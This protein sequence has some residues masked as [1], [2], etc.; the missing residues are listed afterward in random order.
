MSTLEACARAL[1]I[2]DSGEEAAA[3]AAHMEVAGS[4]SLPRLSTHVHP[5]FEPLS[6]MVGALPLFNPSPSIQTTSNPLSPL[7]EHHSLTLTL[8]LR[9]RSILPYPVLHKTRADPHPPPTLRRVWR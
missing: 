6:M 5:R 7:S 4:V 9:N 2:L 1:R 8:A 3:A